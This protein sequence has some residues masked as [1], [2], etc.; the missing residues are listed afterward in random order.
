[1][2]NIDITIGVPTFNEEGNI[3]EFFNSLKKQLPTQDGSVEVIF[4]DDSE[5]KTSQIIDDLRLNNPT[6]NIHLIHNNDR[7]GVSHAWNTI[8]KVANGKVIIL[9]DADII[10]GEKCISRLAKSINREVGLCASN[11]IPY[12][13]D[14]GMYSHAATFIAHWLRSVRLHGLSQYTAMGRALAID[15]QLAKNISIP[16]EII[17]IDLYL[18]CMIIK[19]SKNVIYDD[20][21]LIYFFT[22]NNRKD[23]F[24][25]II[26]A[27]KGH[28]QIRAITS[29][30]DFNAPITLVIK[31][32]LK[33]SKIYPKGAI[34]LLL[35][36][37][38]LPFYYAKNSS[39]VSHI[40]DV[41]YSTKK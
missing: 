21:A 20:K 9:L 11:T 6:L 25:Q 16:D 18:Q 29:S 24:S 33:N 39:K 13:K 2:N 17:A 4:V 41:A 8:F 27:I 22:P 37:C 15:S 12:R 34:Y 40:W 36:Y 26:R 35:C 32:F 7:K 38:G 1:M 28:K 5:D 19:Q 30:L 10:L 31:E 3:R 23:F 14:E